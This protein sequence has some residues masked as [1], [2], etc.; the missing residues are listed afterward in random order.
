M[1]RSRTSIGVNLF[2]GIF[3]S[4]VVV[5][6]AFSFLSSR[7]AE[8][9]WESSFEQHAGQT[10]AVIERVLRQGMLLKKKEAV[11]AALRDVS[12]A[13]GIRSIRIYDKYGEVKFSTDTHES[14]RVSQVNCGMD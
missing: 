10:T 13:P 4:V 14:W 3:G 2:F 11:H 5:F 1:K 6:L 12:T 7:R 9:A 8:D